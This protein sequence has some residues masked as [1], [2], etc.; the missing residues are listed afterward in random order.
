MEKKAY[1]Y[2][3]NLHFLFL[4]AICHKGEKFLE[5]RGFF[6][7][8]LTGINFRGINKIEYFEGTNFRDFGQKL[9]KAQKLV[10]LM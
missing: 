2:K 5:I 3:I 6:S 8:F 10:P 4:T 1:C 9:R 7:I